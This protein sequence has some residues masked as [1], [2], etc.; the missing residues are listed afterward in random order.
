M[1][2]SKERQAAVARLEA[3]KRARKEREGRQEKTKTNDA[4]KRRKA[5]EEALKRIRAGR[6]RRGK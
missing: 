4:V 5:K 6:A 3:Q 2:T 1:A